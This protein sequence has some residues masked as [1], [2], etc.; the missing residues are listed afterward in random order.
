MGRKPN[1][2]VVD[3]FTRGEKHND[4]SNRYP[5]TCKH[6]G[7]H[8][9][10]GRPES[11]MT[12]ITKKCPAISDADRL[13][14]CIMQSGIQDKAISYHPAP[15]TNSHA[16]GI[17]AAALQVGQSWSALETLAEAS[18]QVDMSEKGGNRD[19]TNALASSP[20]NP[21]YGSASFELQEQFTLDNPPTSVD[22]RS[23]KEKNGKPP[24]P[25][26][27][28]GPYRRALNRTLTAT[29]RCRSGT[30]SQW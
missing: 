19:A 20:A 17:A 2:I 27:D 13:H 10:R 28:V 24:L 3:H 12:H 15:A 5:Q 18:R 23:A 26:D 22:G 6:C 9:H 4:N 25:P 14:A 29:P 7:E 8:F 21:A 11:L 1:P 30:L 16:N